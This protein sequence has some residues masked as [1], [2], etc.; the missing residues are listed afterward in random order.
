MIILKKGAFLIGPSDDTTVT[1]YICL[2]QDGLEVYDSSC[3]EGHSVS[4]TTT[5]TT[6]ANENNKESFA[7]AAIA[8]HARLNEVFE[9][10]QEH[11]HNHNI[12]IDINCEELLSQMIKEAGKVVTMIVEL[13][14]LA[15]TND[16]KKQREIDNIIELNN[17]TQANVI[18][19]D[20]DD[21]HSSS[22][23]IYIPPP[24][25]A[26]SKRQRPRSDSLDD[27]LM[28]P[29]RNVHIDVQ[30]HHRRHFS[31]LPYRSGG[32]SS[33]TLP[34][35]PLVSEEESIVD[36][37]TPPSSS[38]TSTTITTATTTFTNLDVV[39]RDTERKRKSR[40]FVSIDHS[41]EASTFS[42][43]DDCEHH[44][45][46][47]DR[48]HE[49]HEEE[50][51]KNNN[52]DADVDV[53]YYKIAAE[54]ACDIVDFVFAGEEIYKSIDVPTTATVAPSSS[55]SSCSNKRPCVTK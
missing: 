18:A 28:G 37:T 46:H 21:H 26:G 7:G 27:A 33:S 11:N 49:E 35:L 19:D 34:L 40:D 44:E 16:T 41:F 38:F 5:S 23:E 8:Q 9:K 53:E 24:P 10:A 31:E 52:N 47:H 43:L 32:S 54:R 36:S 25:T 1:D 12:E 6:N 50:D 20:D 4:A 22:S 2:S 45:D 55:A 17:M 13:T 15:W 48:Y 29:P 30:H 3:H 51:N 42:E 39:H 14:N